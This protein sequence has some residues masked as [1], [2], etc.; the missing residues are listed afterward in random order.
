MEEIPFEQVIVVIFDRIQIMSLSADTTFL[1]T[2]MKHIW[3]NTITYLP[4][5]FGQ[6][7]SLM[8]LQCCCAFSIIMHESNLSQRDGG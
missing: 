3:P 8:S 2:T 6:L 5:E 1:H 7:N 4:A